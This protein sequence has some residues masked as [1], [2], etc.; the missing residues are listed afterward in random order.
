MIIP[1]VGVQVDTD[2]IEQESSASEGRYVFAY[3]I[4]IANHSDQPIQLLNRHWVITN[5]EGSVQEVR[6]EGVVGQQPRI[7]P[8]RGFRYTSGCVLETPVGTMEGA[9]EFIDALGQPFDVPIPV[10][11]LSAPNALH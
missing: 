8:E 6:G 1:D 5:G 11:T 10:F 3:T 7:P 2:Y 4:T 9:Y